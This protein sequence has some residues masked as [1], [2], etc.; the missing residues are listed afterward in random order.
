MG[1]GRHQEA[2]ELARPRAEVEHVAPGTDAELHDEQ[3]NGVVGIRR[4]AP[5]VRGSRGAEALPGDV[6]DPH[7]AGLSQIPSSYG[8]IRFGALSR[9]HTITL[10]RK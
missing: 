3:A 10:R 4:A 2:S 7:Q 8:R 9:F 5:F 6:V 1:A